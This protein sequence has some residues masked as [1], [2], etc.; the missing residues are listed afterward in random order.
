MHT[1]AS[2]HTQTR[3]HTQVPPQYAHRGYYTVNLKHQQGEQKTKIWFSVCSCFRPPSVGAEIFICRLWQCFANFLLFFFYFFSLFFFDFMA[4]RLWWVPLS[5]R[6]VCV[7]GRLLPMI[8]TNYLISRDFMAYIYIN[9]LANVALEGVETTMATTTMTAAEDD[10][11][12][13][14]RQTNWYICTGKTGVL[15]FVFCM[16][17]GYYART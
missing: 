13:G 2:S 4:W 7:L 17:V 5:L 16:Y 8:N 15:F 1:L 11:D 6:S 10:N 12:D 3:A 14:W 9:V